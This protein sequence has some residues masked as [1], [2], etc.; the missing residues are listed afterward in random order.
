MSKI[1]QFRNFIVFEVN[2]GEFLSD[3][4]MGSN[5]DKSSQENTYICFE[6]M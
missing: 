2:E 5:T 1:V 6:V 3:I 4:K